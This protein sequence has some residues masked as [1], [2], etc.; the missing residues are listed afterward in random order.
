MKKLRHRAAAIALVFLLLPYGLSIIYPI[1]Q[2]PSTLMV[3]D[4]LRFQRTTR[5]W[6]P[7]SDISP[8]LINA[9][10]IAEDD[11]FCTHHGIN[12]RQMHKSIKQAEARNRPIKATSTITQ[13]LAKNLFL[14]HGR[15]WLRKMLEVPL[16]LWL[17]LLWSKKEILETY[18]NVIEWDTHVY[19]AEAAA[20]HYFKI[21]AKNLSTSQ[22]ALMATT[23]PNPE[24][25]SAANPTDMQLFT[26][27]NVANRILRDAPDLSCIH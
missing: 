22:A 16:A 12:L 17:E 1:M 15:S 8:N 10:V 26:A 18:L 7:L 11:M 3:W 19:G 4:W 13:Q 27:T 6:V 9:V 14:W 25:R 20:Q 23:L 2:P 5:D 21:S 24:R